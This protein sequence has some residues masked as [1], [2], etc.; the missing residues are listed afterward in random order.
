[1]KKSIILCMVLLSSNALAIGTHDITGFNQLSE[2][3]KADVL[4]HVAETAEKNKTPI[5]PALPS[6]ESIEKYADIGANIAKALGAAAK[7]LGVVANDFLTTPVGFITTGLIVYKVLG[8]DVLTQ[9]HDLLQSLL[10]TTVWVSFL[11]WY[12]RNN[13]EVRIEYSNTRKTLFGNPAIESYHKESM[14]DERSWS[15]VICSFI[16]LTISVILL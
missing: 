5:E 9:I 1:M 3:Q 8:N 16:C 14:T 12:L 6:V 7:E 4:K 10:F 13:S 2:V 11:I 15:I